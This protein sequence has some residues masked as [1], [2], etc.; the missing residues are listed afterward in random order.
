MKTIN[1]KILLVML[2]CVTFIQGVK[3]QCTASFTYTDDGNG[4]FTFNSTSAPAYN[5]WW[6]IDSNYFTGSVATQTFTNGTYQVCMFIEDSATSCYDNTCQ[7]ITVTNGVSC[8][9]VASYAYS[10]GSIGDVTFTSTSTGSFMFEYWD[11]GDGTYYTGTSPQHTYTY[12]GIYNVCVT[13]SDSNQNCSNTF[14]DSIVITNAITAPTCNITS[15]F[16]FVDNGNGNFDFTNTSTGVGTSYS[17]DFGDGG[18]SSLEN[19]NYNFITNGTFV[20]VLAVA[21]LDSN[22]TSC[23]SYYTATITV[24]GVINPVTC[25]AAFVMYTDSS[26]NG[27]IVVNSSTG[28]NLSYFWD[29][30]DGNTSTQAYPN[31]TYATAGPF[32]L[33]LTVT[34]DSSCT[35]TYC[36]SIGAGGIVLKTDGFSINV[37]S[38]VTVGINDEIDL[39][40]TLEF[41]P[42]PVKNNLTV[43]LGLTEQ[44]VVEIFVTDLLGKTVANIVNEEVNVGTNKFIWNTGNAKNGVYLLNIISNH[45]RQIKK[46]VINR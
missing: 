8:T 43:E 35:S 39:I 15:S 25:N 3:S 34:G 33:C 36:D 42:N 2:L 14:C 6:E 11:F 4:T 44:T 37:T 17:W 21:D 24:S 5:V 18:S 23:V 26:Y 45:S 38:P 41:Y 9:S 10:N 32:E 7:T 30:G 1:Y 22:G 16:T 40:S 46:V 12:N 29:F 20:V 19:P 28:S 27:V 31:Y 13:V